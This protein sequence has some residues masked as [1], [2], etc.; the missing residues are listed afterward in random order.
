[1]RPPPAAP[2]GPAALPTR[3]FEATRADAVRSFTDLVGP[4][5]DA[6]AIKM[7]RTRTLDELRPL[8]QMAQTVIGNAR[9]A[10]AAAA[11][12][13]KVYGSARG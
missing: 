2:S 9:G 5:A 13:A 6:L 7:E 4:M 10:Q 3:G 11:Y 1:M 12:L 8:V